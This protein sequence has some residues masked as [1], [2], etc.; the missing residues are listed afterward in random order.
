MSCRSASLKRVKIA[1]HPLVLNAPKH[2]R[3]QLSAP[4]EVHNQ[5]P[6]LA[7]V[8]SRRGVVALDHQPKAKE[9]GK[10]RDRRQERPKLVVDQARVNAGRRVNDLLVVHGPKHEEE[11]CAVALHAVGLYT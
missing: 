5:R 9:K 3:V 4:I 1:L 7:P 2:A 10:E 8:P 11:G 6:G